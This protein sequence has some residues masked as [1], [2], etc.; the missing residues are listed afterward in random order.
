MSDLT[1][2]LKAW[3]DENELTEIDDEVVKNIRFKDAKIILYIGHYCG[4]HLSRG[5]GGFIILTSADGQRMEVPNNDGLNAKVLRARVRK[6]LRHRSTNIPV[7][8]MMGK[9]ISDLKVE[10]SHAHVLQRLAAEVQPVGNISPTTEDEASVQPQ[11]ESV[12]PPETAESEPEPA[13]VGTGRRKRRITKQE[14][15]SAH[16]GATKDG[17]STTYPSQAVMERQW[18]DGTKD[19]ACRWQGCHFTHETPHSVASHFGGHRRGQGT[20]P[21]PP[22]DGIDPDH[23]PAKRARIRR[24]RSEI[25]GAL[26]AA[27]AQGIDFTVVDQ[28]EW[29]ATWIIDH[30]VEPLHS[31]T[32]ERPEEMTAEEA[33]DRIAAIADRGRAVV[34]REQI[35]SLNGQVEGFMERFE[36]IEA[37]H[38]AAEARAKRAEDNLEVVRDLLNEQIGGTT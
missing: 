26:V 25:D 18:S 9:V 15:W 14:P 35:D 20:A 23:A 5:P 13:P 1:D 29:I 28:A 34:L 36:E 4:W 2:N 21:Q 33:L 37:A 7:T 19:F 3:L 22:V 38:H 17:L 31:G 30:R 8:A 24:L 6:I 11:P 12:P 16:K 32:A 10:P 27:V